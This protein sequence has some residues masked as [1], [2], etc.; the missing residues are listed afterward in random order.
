MTENVA[1]AELN[2][3]AAR[4]VA[5]A[6]PLP[7]QIDTRPV[8]E[9]VVFVLGEERFIAS[10]SEIRELLTLPESITR[11]P[12]TRPWMMG[13]ANIRGDLL[14]IVDLQR[15]LE[16]GTTV[17]GRRSR[18]MVIEINDLRVGLHVEDVLGLRTFYEAQRARAV[19]AE[20]ETEKYVNGA[21]EADE[22]Q[23]KVFDMHLLAV[24]ERFQSAAH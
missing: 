11:V 12:G 24:D 22:Q 9:G 14:P 4:C 20:G 10:V 16:S 13:V 18:I 5:N 17:A 6:S 1:L 2:T 3:I 15:Y 8:W 19:M 7:Q 21:F 23:L